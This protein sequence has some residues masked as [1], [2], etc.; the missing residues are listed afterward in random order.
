MTPVTLPKVQVAGYTLTRT[1]LWQ[2]SQTELT[3]LS[4]HNVGTYHGHKPTRNLS[5]N[6]RPQSSQLD[7]PLWTDPGLKSGISVHKLISTLQQTNKQK[8][9]R[10]KGTGK[11]WIVNH[12]PK[13]LHVRKKSSSSSQCE[14]KYNIQSVIWSTCC[15][16]AQQHVYQN[17]SS[18]VYREKEREGCISPNASCSHCSVLMTWTGYLSENLLST[19]TNSAPAV[20]VNSTSQQLAFSWL[21]PDWFFFFLNRWPAHPSLS[22]KK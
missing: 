6:I 22:I 19:W 8:T 20:L 12:S 16:Q 1:H 21:L 11:E 5:G 14:P 7:E 10:K 4:R 13:Y 18:Y 3:M 9:E 2:N 17:K 15:M